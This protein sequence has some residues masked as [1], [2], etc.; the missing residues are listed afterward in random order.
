MATREGQFRALIEHGLELILLI[1]A[2]ANIQYASPAVSRS[3]GHA[4]DALVDTDAFALVHPDERDAHRARFRE[5]RDHPGAHSRFQARLRHADGSWRTI[6]FTVRNLLADSSVAAIA[7]SGRDVTEQAL[8]LQQLE[9]NERRFRQMAENA[10]DVIARYRVLP[11]PCTEYISP[12]V[13]RITGYAPQQFYAD[14]QMHF[15]LIHPEDQ[16]RLHALVSTGTIDVLRDPLTLRWIHRDG[17]VVWMEQII[18]PILDED[19]T[20]TATEAVCRDVSDKVRLEEQLRQSQKMD[21]IGRLAGGIAHDFNNLLGVVLGCADMMR[22]RIP[23]EPRAH[24]ALRS[25]IDASKRGAAL[26]RQLLTFSQRELVEPKI[27]D[28]NE[29]IEDVVPL[30]R[31]VIPEHIDVRTVLDLDVGS[32]EIDQNQLEQVILNLAVNARD[33]MRDGGILTIETFVASTAPPAAGLLIRDTGPGMDEASRARVFEPFFTTKD[34]GRAAGLGLAVVYGIM[35]HS[36][37]SIAC[38]SQ[39]GRGTGFR[40]VW[41]TVVKK[42]ARP[43]RARIREGNGTRETVLVVEDEPSLRLLI[44]EML[45]ESGFE[46]L[47]AEDPSAAIEVSRAHQ[48]NIDLLLTDL[49]LPRING[50]ELAERLAS[51]QPQLRVLFMSG[52]TD[53]EID[54]Q[55]VR[56]EEIAFLPKPFSLDELTEKVR[57]TLDQA[58]QRK[59]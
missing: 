47:Q 43:A 36:G 35:K 9:D 41:P 3:L 12:S 21:A 11:V 40:M 39:L 17:H 56:T 7:I 30:L 58:S 48:G 18:V 49:V 2:D 53:D 28:V 22:R 52:H 16:R 50:R 34:V 37:G 6:D 46:V 4:V 44:G 57:E 20:L 13:E 29:V 24:S 51:T 55:G 54:R 38:E 59:R 8:A 5:L 23:P 1:D 14:P 32:I 31:R 42:R 19:G 25:I 27:L 10:H 26:T 45:E 33:A 15:K